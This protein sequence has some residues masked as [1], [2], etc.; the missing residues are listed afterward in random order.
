[1]VI[2]NQNLVNVVPVK[3][4]KGIMVKGKYY[5]LRAVLE[6]LKQLSLIL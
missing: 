3:Y 2:L 5:H 1:M 4:G 6:N